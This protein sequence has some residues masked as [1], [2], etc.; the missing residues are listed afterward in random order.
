MAVSTIFRTS[1]VSIQHYI[2]GAISG[3]GS[4][5]TPAFHEDA[6]IFGYVGVD[7]LQDQFKV[8]TIGMIQM[9]Q[10]KI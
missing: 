10:P 5:M 3:K 1:I 6:T 8:Y 4:E 2:K 9:G 7:F